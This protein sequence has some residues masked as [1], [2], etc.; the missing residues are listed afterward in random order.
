MRA[1]VLQWVRWV[2]T[3]LDLEPHKME[4]G[5]ELHRMELEL[6]PRMQELLQ[7]Q[8]CCTEEAEEEVEEGCM[9][10]PVV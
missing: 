3:E 7:V 4:L 9:P 1:T 8:V 2:C 5:L 10:E 6:E